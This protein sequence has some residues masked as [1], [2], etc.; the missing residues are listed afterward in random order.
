LEGPRRDYLSGQIAGHL[1]EGVT[2]VKVFFVGKRERKTAIIN[3]F[4]RGTFP[5][6][7]YGISADKVV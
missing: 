4:Q 7:K 5:M 3:Y 1:F 6:Y 2:S